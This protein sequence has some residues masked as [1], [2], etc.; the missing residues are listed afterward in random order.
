MREGFSV[1]ATIEALQFL[2]PCTLCDELVVKGDDCP[3]W[4]V[5]LVVKFN[6]WLNKTRRVPSLKL[7]I[8]I[9]NNR[10]RR[11]KHQNYDRKAA[12]GTSADFVFFPVENPPFILFFLPRKFHSIRVA[13]IKSPH[14]PSTGAGHVLMGLPL[15]YGCPPR[16]GKSEPYVVVL[17]VGNAWLVGVGKRAP[18]GFRCP[19]VVSP[20]GSLDRLKSLYIISSTL[21][22]K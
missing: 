20:H 17:R 13:R 8:P 22:S 3:S 9:R 10:K 11:K 19:C 4:R 7:L 5:S 16:R 21:N 1:S 6:I 12:H 2:I 14:R 15:T 18:H